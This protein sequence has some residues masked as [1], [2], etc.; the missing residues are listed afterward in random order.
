MARITVAPTT[1]PAGETGRRRQRCPRAHGRIL[2]RSASSTARSIM[3]RD[4]PAES[5]LRSQSTRVDD[6]TGLPESRAMCRGPRDTVALVHRRHRRCARRPDAEVRDLEDVT[7]RIPRVRHSGSC[8]AER[9]NRASGPGAR[10]APSSSCS[11]LSGAPAI[12]VD[13]RRT[14]SRRRVRSQRCSGS[15]ADISLASVLEPGDQA[16]L[17]APDGGERDCVTPERRHT[18]ARGHA[19]PNISKVTLACGTRTLRC[20]ANEGAGSAG[21][22]RSSRACTSGCWGGPDRRVG[23]SRRG[24]R[25]RDT[26]HPGLAGPARTAGSR[27]RAPG[28]LGRPG[29]RARAGHERRTPPTP[30]SSSW[31]RSGTRVS[32]ARAHADHLAG[33]I[34]I[35]MA[36]GLEKRG[37]AVRPVSRRLRARSRPR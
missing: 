9:R 12:A 11:Q 5:Q 36:N 21:R 33:K 19:A 14:G 15:R 6:D 4:E 2:R 28:A 18:A 26:G 16:V 1:A 7:V 31:P 27:R 3:R 32:T 13:A 8:G 24:W 30:T 20:W 37:R 23:G 29:R 34:V 17:F 22:V 10:H 35:S 25:R